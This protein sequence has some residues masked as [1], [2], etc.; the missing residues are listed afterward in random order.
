MPL[1]RSELI[2]SEKEFNA[3]RASGKSGHDQHQF[4]K[5]LLC[6]EIKVYDS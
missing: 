2:A 1:V 4:V 3:R 5:Y 6:H